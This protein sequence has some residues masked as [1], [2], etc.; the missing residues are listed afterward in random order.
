MPWL[1]ASIAA[2]EEPPVKTVP[3]RCA[4]LRDQI[5]DSTTSSAKVKGLR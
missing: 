1:A 2:S 3:E 5:D 4:F